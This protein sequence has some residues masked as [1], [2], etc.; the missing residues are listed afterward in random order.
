MFEPAL[1]GSFALVGTVLV[2][3]A[4]IDS[5][6]A[7]TG[8]AKT[9]FGVW[10]FPADDSPQVQIGSTFFADVPLGN[11]DTSFLLTGAPGLQG[12]SLSVGYRIGLIGRKVGSAGTVRMDISSVT[13]SGPDGVDLVPSAETAVGDTLVFSFPSEAGVYYTVQS[14]TD[15][16]N[17]TWT[18]LPTLLLGTGSNL[19]FHEPAGPGSAKQYRLVEALPGQ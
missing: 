18:D 5:S 11:G 15:L 7:G 8:Q 10:L 19:S 9:R 16:D 17:E 6:V 2:D 1:A 14:T 13:I 4:G 12:I 3:E